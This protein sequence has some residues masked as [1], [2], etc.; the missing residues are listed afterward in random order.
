MAFP[1]VVVQGVQFATDLSGNILN[2]TSA[3]GSVFTGP[4]VN[5]VWM[6]VM[7]L[8]RLAMN[9]TGS[10]TLDSRDSLG[11]ITLGVFSS[12]LS[13]AVNQIGFPFAGASATSIRA[14]LTGT[15]TASVI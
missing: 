2:I 8:F 3:S 5:S 9:G 11:N 15:A 14:T 7:S 1:N 13:A 6:P 12:T 4:M 10:V